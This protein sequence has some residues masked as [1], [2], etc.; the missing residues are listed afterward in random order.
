MFKTG[1]RV[2]DHTRDHTLLTISTL[3]VTSIKPYH[4]S[5]Y[6]TLKN[7][8]SISLTREVE[9]KIEVILNDL[10]QYS[11]NFE[12]IAYDYLNSDAPANW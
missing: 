8:G 9:Q 4:G 12:I 6:I 2:E 7:K 10:A 3:E 5:V 1:R 11:D